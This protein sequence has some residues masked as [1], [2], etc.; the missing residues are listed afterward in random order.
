MRQG[1]EVPQRSSNG[2][3][4]SGRCTALGL[5]DWLDWRDNTWEAAILQTALGPACVKRISG[6]MCFRAA[7]FAFSLPILKPITCTHVWNKWNEYC[8]YEMRWVSLWVWR[9][10]FVPACLSERGAG[11]SPAS[12]IAPWK[13]LQIVVL[14]L[15]VAVLRR[16]IE[17]SA[18]PH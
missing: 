15:E 13:G 2:H 7:I 5:G 14:G 4:N 1:H 9:F 18:H 17:S 16:R 8:S 10:S 3:P 12:M 6:C 11:L